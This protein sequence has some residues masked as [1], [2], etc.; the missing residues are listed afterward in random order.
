V[1]EPLSPWIRGVQ[2]VSGRR[3]RASRRALGAG[4]AELSEDV[5]PEV[6]R[7]VAET[8][9]LL[10]TTVALSLKRA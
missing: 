6:R 8:E 7:A 9:A 2:R 4:A 3:E 10:R 5:D 1:E